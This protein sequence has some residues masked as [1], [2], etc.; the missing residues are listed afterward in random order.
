MTVYLCPVL[1][2][3]PLPSRVCW[4]TMMIV[5]MTM[6]TGDIFREVIKS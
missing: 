6:M 4:L 2:P 3:A 1:R 5:M